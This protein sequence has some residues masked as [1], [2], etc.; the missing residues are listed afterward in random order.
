MSAEFNALSRHGTW[1][2]IP[3]PQANIIGCHWV[4]V[5]K[6]KVDG[7]VD[8]YKAR[9]VAKGFNQR[10]GIDYHETFSPV[11]ISVTIRTILALALFHNWPLRQLD[12][13]NA[14][15]HGTLSEPV[16]ISHPSG[17]VDSESP[18]FVCRLR[19]SLYGLRQAPR[20]WYSAL[21]TSL[22]SFRFT[23][24]AADS[25]LF[26]LHKDD[27]HLFILVNVDDFINYHGIQCFI[28]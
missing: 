11:V 28:I 21:S 13:S 7:S 17:F 10:P 3:P 8:K 14:F 25:S 1:D 4:F 23:Q 24:S 2:L 27:I 6:R 18:T 20:A 9:L 16:Y 19:K 26:I 22:L 5:I 15:L 12:I